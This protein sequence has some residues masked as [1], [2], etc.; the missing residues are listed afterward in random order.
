MEAERI[1][2]K[3]RKQDDKNIGKA[4]RRGKER[5]SKGNRQQKNQEKIRKSEEKLEVIAEGTNRR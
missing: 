3:G 2:E 5:L 1:L 4:G